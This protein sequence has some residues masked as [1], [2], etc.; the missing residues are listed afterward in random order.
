MQYHSD[1]ILVAIC[2]VKLYRW[3]ATIR[4]LGP[5]KLVQHDTDNGAI[6]GGRSRYNICKINQLETHHIWYLQ[7]YI[8]WCLLHS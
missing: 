3:N 8:L 7:T 6:M 5:K 2:G 4:I 1:E